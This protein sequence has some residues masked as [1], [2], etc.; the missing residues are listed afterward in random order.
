VVADVL[1]RIY[2][3]YRSV[4]AELV[5]VNP[6][7]LNGEGAVVAMDAK[8]SLDPGATPRHP[9]SLRDLVSQLPD[10]ATELVREARELDLVLIELDG[11]V[12]VLANGA[13]RTMTTLDAVTHYGGTPANFLERSVEMPTPRPR[14]LSGWSWPTRGYAAWS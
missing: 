2:D 11:S 3:V 12:G 4:D 14:P 9:D 6:L 13:G 10:T 5:E 8:I 7:A 1:V